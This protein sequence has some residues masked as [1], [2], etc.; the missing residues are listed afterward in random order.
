MRTFLPAALACLALASVMG[1][2]LIAATAGG[3]PAKVPAP[4]SPPPTAPPHPASAAGS[5]IDN[6]APARHARR[7]ACLK[8]AKSKKLVGAK[9]DDYVRNCVGTL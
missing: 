3:S 4:A 8:D 6:D 1:G 2:W 7:T 9:R 5:S